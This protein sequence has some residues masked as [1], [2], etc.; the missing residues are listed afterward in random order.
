MQTPRIRLL[1]QM[2]ALAATAVHAV[3]VKPAKPAAV[4]KERKQ[5]AK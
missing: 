3:T 5:P 4:L 2:L 1:A